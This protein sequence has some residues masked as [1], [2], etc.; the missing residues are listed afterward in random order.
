MNL[1]K[2]K[3]KPIINNKNKKKNRQHKSRFYLYFHYFLLL[4]HLQPGYI[5]KDKT[6]SK[7][8]KMMQKEAK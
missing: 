5:G 1:I 8:I 4:Q 3:Y 2:R 7:K 6:K